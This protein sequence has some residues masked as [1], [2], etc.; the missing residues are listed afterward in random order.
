MTW[1]RSAVSRKVV[2]VSVELEFPALLLGL[3]LVVVNQGRPGLILAE[4][5]GDFTMQ[6]SAL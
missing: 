4:H 1:L 2:C 5:L 6:R 3:G